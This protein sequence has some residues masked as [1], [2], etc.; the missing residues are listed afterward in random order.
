MKGRAV[1][2]SVEEGVVDPGTIDSNVVQEVVSTLTGMGPG[3]SLQV[4]PRSGGRQR[5]LYHFAHFD[6]L[7]PKFRTGG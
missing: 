3:R 4:S 5:W 6:I 2:G 7:N 1:V